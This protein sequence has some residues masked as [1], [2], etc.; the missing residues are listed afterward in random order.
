[1]SDHD[2]IIRR[3]HRRSEGNLTAVATLLGMVGTIGLVLT[4]ACGVIGWRS[5][6][7][8]GA[9]SPSS[10]LTVSGPG[11]LGPSA[12]SEGEKWSH[13]ELAAYLTSKGIPLV[14]HGTNK[15]SLW[16]P[17]AYLLPP[18]V[19]FMDGA[20]F[21][22]SNGGVYVQIR[23]TSQSAKDE[24]GTE[25]DQAFSWGRFLFVTA[26]DVLRAKIKKSLG[27]T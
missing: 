26:D 12:S 11:L 9:E 19:E 4:A 7:P 18:D 10:A 5:L 1:M 16:G 15:G 22:A 23:N 2:P 8:A 13:P 24:A 6:K 20:A 3:R 25:P 21:Y 27:I 17:A 14:V